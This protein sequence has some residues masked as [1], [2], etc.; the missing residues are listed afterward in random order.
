MGDRG[1]SFAVLNSPPR[2]PS[3]GAVEVIEEMAVKRGVV[4]EGIAEEGVLLGM[5]V[6]IVVA[7]IAVEGEDEGLAAE[8]VMVERVEVLAAEITTC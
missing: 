1:V 2:P 3:S 5:A 7:V 6:E 4:V 8:E